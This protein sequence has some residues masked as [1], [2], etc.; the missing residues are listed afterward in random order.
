MRGWGADVGLPALLCQIP[1]GAISL[2]Q[3]SAG[4]EKNFIEKTEREIKEVF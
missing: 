3:K 1:A 4:S 2:V